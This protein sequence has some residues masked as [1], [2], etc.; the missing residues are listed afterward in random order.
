[1]IQPTKNKLQPGR[2]KKAFVFIVDDE[3]LLLDLAELSLKEDGY[4]LKKFQDPEL[5]LKSFLAAKSKPDLLISDYAM[6]KMNGL[7]LI[8]KCKQVHP[9][10]K[11]ILVSG[12]MGVEIILDAPVKVDR[13]MGKPY[14]SANLAELVRRV[15][16]S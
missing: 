11:T 16:A 1:M 8:E 13:F 10:L 12:T 7:E 3:A 2:K 15:L 4:T 9:G 14:Q 5:A 6:G